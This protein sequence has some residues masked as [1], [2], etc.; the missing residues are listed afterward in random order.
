MDGNAQISTDI[1]AR[2]AADAAS[3]VAGV[4]SLVDRAL[5]RHRGVRIGRDDRAVTAEVHVEVE[6]GASIPDVGRAVQRRVADYLETMAD[7]RPARVDVVVDDIGP[8]D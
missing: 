3:E 7:A 2:Y 6:W 4:R 1:L 5:P 8:R